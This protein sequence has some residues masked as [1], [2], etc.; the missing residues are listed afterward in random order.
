MITILPESESDVLAVAVSGRLTTEDYDTLEPELELRAGHDGT[1][2]LLVELTDVEGV[3]PAAIRDDLSF[4]K[5]YSDDIGRM[6]VVTDDSLMKRLTDFLGK[7]FSVVMGVDM[8]RF[9]DRVEARK[10]LRS[11]RPA[12]EGS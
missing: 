1:F 6:A 3:E 2:D 8:E 11:G 5:K 12:A 4:S 7:P 10:W 9:D